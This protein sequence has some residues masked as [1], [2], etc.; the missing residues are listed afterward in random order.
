ML[1]KW[2]RDFLR[3][4]GGFRASLK[5][6]ARLGRIFGLR[7][8]GRLDEALAEALAL[9]AEL[10]TSTA[11]LA[12]IDIVMATATIDEI[13]ERLDRHDVAYDALVDGIATIEKLKAD[14]V[15]KLHPKPGDLESQLEPYHRRFRDSLNRIVSRRNR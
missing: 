13:A 5:Y 7:K 3:G 12:S 10:K 14:S 11:L 1:L 4:L 15:P 6:S 9:S 2:W 8:K